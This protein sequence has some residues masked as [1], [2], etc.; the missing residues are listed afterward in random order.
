MANRDYTIEVVDL[1]S[2]D[3]DLGSALDP[4]DLERAR[5]HARVRVVRISG[6]VKGPGWDPQPVRQFATP[7]WLGLLVVNGLMMRCVSVGPRSACELFGPGDLV[8]PWDADGEYEPLSI[9]LQWRILSGV[10]LAVLDEAFAM[11]TR[12][13][14][15]IT[16]R[17]M[18]RIATRARTLALTQAISHLNRADSRVIFFFWLLAERWGVVTPSG[19]TIELP[20]THEVIAMLV[21]VRRPTATIAINRL[22]S[23]GLLLRPKRHHWLLTREAIDFLRGPASLKSLENSVGGSAT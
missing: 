8:R 21:G 22:G 4:H 7:Q 19:I 9:E 17:L 10:E 14:P 6:S 16:S 18:G 13:W 12:E 15:S 23:D 3:P 11:R 2:I 20:L 1:L 5:V